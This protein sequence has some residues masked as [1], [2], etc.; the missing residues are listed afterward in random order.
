MLDPVGKEGLHFF[1]VMTAS[2]SHE[3]KN[4]MAI[5]NEQAG[6]LEDLVS[7]SRQGRE[8]DVSRIERLA[9]SVKAQIQMADT[10]IKTMNRFAHSIDT[11]THPADLNETVALSILLFKR[12]AGNREIQLTGMSCDSPV[13]VTTA[14]FLLMN[15]LWHWLAAVMETASRNASVTIGAEP[16]PDGAVITIKWE[17][18]G[19]GT[20]PPALPDEAAALRQILKVSA[21]RT[22]ENAMIL[23][24]PRAL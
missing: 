6:L 1:G 2:I 24:L 11:M 21:I 20:P 22:D 16:A 13:S 7:M 18:Q 8:I 4:R 9:A 23:S 17:S 19:E 12:T 15:L 3:I 14:P 10:I 5:I